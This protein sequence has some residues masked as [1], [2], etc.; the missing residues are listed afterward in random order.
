MLSCEFYQISK[1]TFPYRTPL[2]AAFVLPNSTV[3]LPQL[4]EIWHNICIEF[5]CCSGCDVTNFL[6]NLNFFIISFYTQ[7]KSSAKN[8][9]NL[10]KKGFFRE[11]KSILI[12]FK[13]LS[14]TKIF[15]RPES[16]SLTQNLCLQYSE[17]EFIDVCYVTKNYFKQ[18]IG[19]LILN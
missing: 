11:I 18:K 10:K 14:V 12:I 6:I 2:M 4:L 13:G 19:A 9:N 5:F 3:W 1:N 7:T 17:I 16:A 8:L 15:L